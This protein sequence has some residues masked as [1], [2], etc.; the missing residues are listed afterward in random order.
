MTI[1]T[2]T[3]T[4]TNNPP[5]GFAHHDTETPPVRSFAHDPHLDPDL[6]WAGKA[7]RQSFEVE[8]PSI[9]V[10]EL[11]STEA[12]VTSAQRRSDADRDQLA[13]FADE[14]IDDEQLDQ[15]LEWFSSL[16]QEYVAGDDARRGASAP[17]YG[18]SF[19]T[20]R[21]RDPD[22]GRTE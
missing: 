13:L 1:G 22:D 2:T 4:R 9:Q 11:M 6:S 18:A 5:V 16:L 15:F 12:I 20:H 14:R 19:A 21:L 3:R 7:E 17:A 10:H 8:A